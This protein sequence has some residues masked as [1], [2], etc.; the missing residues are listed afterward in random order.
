M[1]VQP[2]SRRPGARATVG[3]C[4]HDCG[5]SGSTHRA[6]RERGRAACHGYLSVPSPGSDREQAA[7]ASDR[8][9]RS[10]RAAA[11][12][13]SDP[14][15]MGRIRHVR[16][17]R[18]PPHV[19]TNPTRLIQDRGVARPTWRVPLARRDCDDCAQ[20]KMAPDRLGQR[21]GDDIATG[22]RTH[23]CA[24][25]GLIVVR[26]LPPPV[27]TGLPKP[28]TAARGPPVADRIW[29]WLSTS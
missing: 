6:R 29:E 10:C 5:G 17:R 28:G 3:T 14:G 23:R 12:P 15:P 21:P 4:P 24:R 8:P 22:S 2:A 27:A 16:P 7:I 18:R 1:G 25:G 9:S 19:R 26:T 13:G 11:P 20:V